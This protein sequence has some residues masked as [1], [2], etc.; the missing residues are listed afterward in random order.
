MKP[1]KCDLCKKFYD[2]DKYEVCPHCASE[3]T[4]ISK[5]REP[6]AEDT[7]TEEKPVSVR[8]GLFSKLNKGIIPKMTDNVDEACESISDGVSIAS[9]TSSEDNSSENVVKATENKVEEN[10]QNEVKVENII[11]EK[12]ENVSAVKITEAVKQADSTGSAKDVKTVAFYNF[13]NDI[14][15]VVGWLVCIKGEYKGESFKLKSGR[16]NIGRAL[17]MDIP[18]AQEKSVSRERHASVTFDP[19]QCKFFAQSGDGRGLTY[20]NKELLMTFKELK[21]GDIIAVSSCE[22]MFYPLCGEEFSW[23]NY[24]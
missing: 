12:E 6:F 1:I 4:T 10:L 5:R 8:K 13:S 22:L 23:D 11:E 7:N 15:P 24:E 14:D 17:T 9:D 3:V 20:V 21:K 18:L 16:N 2:A 19:Q